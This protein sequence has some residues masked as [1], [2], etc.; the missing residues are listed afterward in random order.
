[1]GR[2][3]FVPNNAG[4]AALR[5]DPKLVNAMET[6][7]REAAA[8]TGVDLEVVAWPHQGIRRGPRTSVQIWARS[9]RARI[10]VNRNPSLLTSVL[11]R[12]GGGLNGR[13]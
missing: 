4:F 8:A 13:G 10:A 11:G 6:A 9:I 1:M 5:N 2:A 12:F 3:R 7:A